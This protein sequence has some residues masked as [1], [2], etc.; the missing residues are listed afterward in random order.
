MTGRFGL[1]CAPGTRTREP[2]KGRLVPRARPDGDML[3]EG[4]TTKSGIVST[5]PDVILRALVG[6]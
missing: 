2:W 1:L 5:P 6:T 3:P 4:G